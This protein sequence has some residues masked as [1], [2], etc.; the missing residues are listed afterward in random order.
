M[1]KINFCLNCGAEWVDDPIHP[2]NDLCP[3][4]YQPAFGQYSS[5]PIALLNTSIATQDGSYTLQTI[6]LAQAQ[7]F[8]N[9]QETLSAIGHE[10]TAQILSDLLGVTVPVNRINFEQQPGQTALV[11]KLNGR[12]PEG[13][14]LSAEEI[15]T[16]GYKFQIL[17]REK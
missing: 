12:P 5:H 16:I 4:C 3:I 15:E 14:I 11:F 7:E 1:K 8:I 9:G 17:R 2:Q 6:T 13:K 10:S